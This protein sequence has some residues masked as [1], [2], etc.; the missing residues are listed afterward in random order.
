MQQTTIT[1]PQIILSPRH[2]HKLRGYF[3]TY[4]AEHSPLLHNHLE[5]QKDQF[6]KAYPL[7]QYKVV[8]SVPMLVGFN[9]GAKL[10]MDLFLNIN[11]IDINGLKIPVQQ[12]NIACVE[13]EVGYTTE[14][15]TYQFKTLWMPFNQKNYPKWRAS[16]E[17]GRTEILNRLLTNQI[18]FALRGIDAGP[19][20]EQRLMC[21]IN[22]LSDRKTNFKN[23]RMQAFNG[24]FIV[25]AE[26]PKYLG[27]GR[28]TS[29]GFG[30]IISQD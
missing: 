10:L 11:E 23:Q 7:V 13:K 8:E 4:F 5:G 19:T 15:L 21:K 20:P 2:A 6:R 14:L 26:L 28:A 12:K 1:F 29:R 17:K 30:T 16:D 22:Q 18:V 27:L 25:N 3:G 9:E 24:Q